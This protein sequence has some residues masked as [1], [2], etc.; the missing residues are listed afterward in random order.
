MY[1]ETNVGKPFFPDVILYC[2]NGVSVCVR[3]LVSTWPA[4]EGI[5]WSHREL[6]RQDKRRPLLY[7]LTP[8]IE[9]SSGFPIGI[10]CCTKTGKDSDAP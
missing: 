1:T 5:D 7:H 9:L 3:G 2:L 6:L 10:D 4:E 8:L